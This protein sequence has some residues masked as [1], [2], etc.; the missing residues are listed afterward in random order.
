M[1][2]WVQSTE[3]AQGNVY[4]L[5]PK[6]TACD[7]GLRSSSEDFVEG[8]L[9]KG[10]GGGGGQDES[11][12]QPS[13]TEKRSGHKGQGAEGMVKGHGESPGSFAHSQR[14]SQRVLGP[15]S[16]GDGESPG[17]FA[18]SQR[19][20]AAGPGAPELWGWIVSWV[21]CAQ[22]KVLRSGSR[23][24][25]VVGMESLLGPLRAA[26]GSPQRVLGPQSC[27]DGESPGSFARSQRLSAAGPGA[28]ELWGFSVGV[29][30]GRVA[31]A[32][33]FS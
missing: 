15:Q 4:R 25:R 6:A 20:S 24:P 11:N 7:M 27:G 8:V 22:P 21:L 17:S 33:A 32:N 16:C 2:K 14:L 1:M 13:R 12:E 23:G 10:V 26:K 9:G 31:C 18:H 29:W 5:W 28:P 3:R 19:L 30:R